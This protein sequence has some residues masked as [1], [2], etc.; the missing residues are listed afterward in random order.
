MIKKTHAFDWPYTAEVAWDHQE[1]LTSI[2]S[3]KHR[4]ESTVPFTISHLANPRCIEHVRRPIAPIIK[5]AIK[6]QISRVWI[7]MLH[8]GDPSVVQ[9]V[10]KRLIKWTCFWLPAGSTTVVATTDGFFGSVSISIHVLYGGEGLLRNCLAV[11]Y[12]G[13]LVL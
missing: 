3:S 1:K 13:G 7:I 10:R 8:V 4:V 5:P 6:R 2:T 11:L 12:E 9:C